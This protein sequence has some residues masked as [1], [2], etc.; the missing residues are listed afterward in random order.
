[1]THWARVYENG[2]R[3]A[4]VTG[5]DA[6]VLLLFCLFHDA[7]RRTEGWDQG[8]GVRGA[9]LAARWRGKYFELPPAQFDLLYDACALHTD[10]LTEGDPSLQT[11][12]DADRLDL[13]RASILPSA[14][15]L[16]TLAAREKAVMDWATER[17]LRRSA[18]DWLLPEWGTPPG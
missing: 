18:P 2:L 6:Q 16:C 5:G 14:D 13:A 12:W 17:S 8:H 4:P 11:C 1:M 9:E 15:R 7:C 3:L 10:G